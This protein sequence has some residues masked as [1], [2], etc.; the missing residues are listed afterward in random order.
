MNRS[1]APTDWRPCEPAKEEGKVAE[2]VT[3]GFRGKL[4][5]ARRS[6]AARL[7]LVWRGGRHLQE[8]LGLVWSPRGECTIYRGEARSASPSWTTLIL[9]FDQQQF[10]T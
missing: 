6:L 9:M 3:V 8:N 5:Q 7:G 2:A 4:F 10:I 1:T